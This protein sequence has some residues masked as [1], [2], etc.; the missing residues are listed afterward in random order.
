MGKECKRA[1]T[2]SDKTRHVLRPYCEK[3]KFIQEV[4]NKQKLTFKSRPAREQCP[5]SRIGSE[6]E[7]AAEAERRGEGLQGRG[8]GAGVGT[9]ARRSRNL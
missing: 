7:A 4:H 1:Q 3:S 2:L 5:P 6:A 8:H 9:W